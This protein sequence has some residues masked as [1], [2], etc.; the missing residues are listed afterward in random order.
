MSF[1]RTQQDLPTRTGDGWQEYICC[2]PEVFGEP[3]PLRTVR[4]TLAA[5][6][7]GPD[8]DLSGDEVMLYVAA[9]SGELTVL[10]DA[11]HLEPESMAWLPPGGS[12]RLCAGDD[13]L[14]VL[15]SLAPGASG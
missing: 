12:L 10:N 8:I 6:A 4:Y 14:D 2:A 9:G 1:S 13:G 5:G 15:L 11:A 3:V 7:T